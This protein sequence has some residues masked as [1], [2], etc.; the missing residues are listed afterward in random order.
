MFIIHVH[1]IVFNVLILS[2]HSFVV[3]I[4][5]PGK[6]TQW[7]VWTNRTD[8]RRVQNLRGPQKTRDWSH[9]KT[10]GVSNWGCTETNGERKRATEEIWRNAIQERCSDLRQLMIGTTMWRHPTDA[11]VLWWHVFVTCDIAVVTWPMTCDSFWHQI[12][13]RY[14]IS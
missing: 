2:F 3:K 12:Q 11:T 6:A 14:H 13:N 10:N 7:S 9:T 8:I 4:P 5:G 1:V